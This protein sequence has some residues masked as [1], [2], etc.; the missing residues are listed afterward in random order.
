[1]DLVG[2]Y[3]ALQLGMEGELRVRVWPGTWPPR[4]VLPTPTHHGGLRTHDPESNEPTILAATNDDR[5]NS[6]YIIRLCGK[7]KFILIN[8]CRIVGHNEGIRN[9]GTL[10]TPAQQL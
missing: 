4:A 10:P 9:I 2:L 5:R 7:L 3:S 8:R 1:M 6:F